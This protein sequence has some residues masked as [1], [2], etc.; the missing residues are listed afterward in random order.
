MQAPK[1]VACYVVT[2]F[3]CLR[4]A[5]TSWSLR[6]LRTTAGDTERL[7]V[8]RAYPVVPFAY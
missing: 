5:R 7:E 3:I 1:K 2:A 8:L 6:A 4:H